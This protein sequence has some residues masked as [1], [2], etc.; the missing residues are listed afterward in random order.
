[1]I[2]KD[3]GSNPGKD[4]ALFILFV[5][6]L[7]TIWIVQG[8]PSKSSQK[9]LF[10]SFPSVNTSVSSEEQKTERQKISEIIPGGLEESPY[11]GKIYL[12]AASASEAD[13][14]KE[15]IEISNYQAEP[16]LVTGWTLTNRYSAKLTIGEAASY[17][18]SGQ[19]NVQE[20]IYLKTNERAVVVT[21]R[22]PIGT[23]FKLNVCTG[24]FNQFQEFSPRLPEECPRFSE[25]EIPINYPAAC[26]NFV[27]NLPRCRMPMSI[28]AEV[29]NDCNNLISEKVSYHSCTDSHKNDNNF[30]RP[31]WRIYLNQSAEFWNNERDYIILRDKDGK[32]VDEIS[33]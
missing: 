22:S 6:I 10:Y 17:V 26:F 1:M 29:G 27:Q 30:Y 33:Y 19:V 18:F 14:Q 7:I 9:G 2:E 16:V 11:K 20:D 23:S 3:S 28:P 5:F 8:G 15:Y 31:E 21:G 13:P 24:Y 12:R 25:S 4:L 32:L